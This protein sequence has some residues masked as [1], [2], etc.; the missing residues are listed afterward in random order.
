MG[1]RFGLTQSNNWSGYGLGSLTTGSTYGQISGTWI[2]P[3]AA[4]K[5]A[6]QQES[7][8][9]WIGIGGGCADSSCAITDETLI[10][11]GTEQDVSA[12]GRASYSSWYELLP[13]PA[14][15]TSLAVS[16]GNAMAIDIS[17]SIP[18][19]WTISMKNLSTGQSFSTTLPYPSTMLTAEWIEESPV[20]ISTS[21]SSG[22]LPIPNL[23]TVQF[24]NSRVNSSLPRFQPG[25][26]IELVSASGNVEALPSAPDPNVDAFN[27][28][29]YPTASTCPAPPEGTL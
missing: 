8:A 4:Q 16:P 5:V 3:K 10:Q 1:S 25:Q 26:R 27:D 28:C 11:A 17:Q 29:T 9:T 14:V 24:G 2:V 6:G 18:E 7:S 21:G 13:L 19:V 22:I 12:S 23:G 15:T 20:V